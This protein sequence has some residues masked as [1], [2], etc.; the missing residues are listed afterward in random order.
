MI[1]NN[2][3]YLCMHL[4]FCLLVNLRIIMEAINFLAFHC[5]FSS[6]EYLGAYPLYLEYLG[7]FA[8][9]LNYITPD[10]NP[11]TSPLTLVPVSPSCSFLVLAQHFLHSPAPLVTMDNNQVI[12][13]D[14]PMGNSNMDNAT[15]D[16][17]VSPSL[18]ILSN[19]HGNELGPP[20][21]I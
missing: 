4:C 14:A 8:Y 21:V 3:S 17:I 6:L 15:S 20:P 7:A 5:N 12:V 13:H 1:I 2:G 11:V 9:P 18:N 19:Y 16:S 10:K